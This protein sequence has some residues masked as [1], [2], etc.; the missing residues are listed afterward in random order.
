[1]TESRE[2]LIIRHILLSLTTVGLMLL[3]SFLLRRLPAPPGFLLIVILAINAAGYA[4][5]WWGCRRWLGPTEPLIWVLAFVAA[6]LALRFHAPLNLAAW[7]QVTT[8]CASIWKTVAVVYGIE[9]FKTPA[10]ERYD[11]R[12]GFMHLGLVGSAAFILL[13]VNVVI[14]DTF[15]WHFR[16]APLAG[17]VVY[18]VFGGYFMVNAYSGI[19]AERCDKFL[20]MNLEAGKTVFRYLKLQGRPAVLYAINSYGIWLG[21]GALYFY[22]RTFM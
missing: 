20:D 19:R 12:R 3:L 14:M 8:M 2:Q 4:A 18:M 16:N 22:G 6:E 9:W 15:I 21:L 5:Y 7:K 13:A 1:M 10:A 11:R 17:V